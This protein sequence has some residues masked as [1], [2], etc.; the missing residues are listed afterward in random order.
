MSWKNIIHVVAQSS[1]VRAELSRGV[2]ALGYHAEIYADYGELV[3]AGPRRGVVLA[4]DIFDAG[5]VCALIAAMASA[6]FWLPV[7]ATAKTAGPSQVVAAVRC[8]AYDYLV[9]YDEPERLPEVLGKALQ[10][11]E[12]MGPARQEAAEATAKLANLTLRE[13][14]VLDL[15]V[16]GSSNKAIARQLDISPRTVEIHRS[17]MMSKLG[18]NHVADAIRWRLIAASN[19]ELNRA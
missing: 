19:S 18:A 9:P 1:V 10:Y 4:E 16:S 7:I 13:G 2:F 15:L 3:S 8:G 17:N 5:G 11:A 12:V 14:E 6:G